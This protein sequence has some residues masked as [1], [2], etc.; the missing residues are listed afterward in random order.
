MRHQHRLGTLV[1]LAAVFLAPVAASAAGETLGALTLKG[2]TRMFVLVEDLSE[3]ASNAA[4]M[5]H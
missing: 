5:V 3:T 1:L 4:V 2:L